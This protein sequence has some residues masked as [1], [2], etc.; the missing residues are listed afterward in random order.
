MKRLAFVFILI[1]MCLLPC[2][3]FAQGQFSYSFENPEEASL[4]S[5]GVFDGSNYFET[6]YSI[7]V[8]NPFGELRGE[9]ITHVLD[10]MPTVALEGGKVYNLSGY[11]FNPLSIYSPSVRSSATA[12]SG[13]NNIILSVSCIGDEWSK[14]STTF[15]VGE[16]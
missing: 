15:Y 9:L 1:L 16:S 7:Y 6:G 8:N 13:T 11:V 12:D 4:W 5:G 2:A 14:F 3:S 10:Y